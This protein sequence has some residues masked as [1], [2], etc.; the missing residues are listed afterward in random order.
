L[1]RNADLRAPTQSHELIPLMKIGIRSSIVGNRSRPRFDKFETAVILA[2]ASS[3]YKSFGAC[4]WSALHKE[5]VKGN[6]DQ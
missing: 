2:L 3:K 4:K 5:P 6:I 1:R